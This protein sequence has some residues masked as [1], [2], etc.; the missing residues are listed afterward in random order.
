VILARFKQ[1]L[2][3]IRLPLIGSVTVV[4]VF[5]LFQ[6][7]L[8]VFNSPLKILNIPGLSRDGS[9]PGASGIPWE[10]LILESRLQNELWTTFDSVGEADQETAFRVIIQLKDRLSSEQAVMLTE[11]L[12][13]RF[14]N[15]KDQNRL[16][17]FAHV[18][19]KL[20]KVFEAL[21]FK[22]QQT[23]RTIA[24]V[25]ANW[26]GRDQLEIEP[27]IKA[28]IDNLS[29]KNGRFFLTLCL[30][31]A[32]SERT[33]CLDSIG[34]Y[35]GPKASEALW[36]HAESAAGDKDR[37]EIYRRLLQQQETRPK[38]KLEVL[39]LSPREADVRL[40]ARLIG[41]F[42]L[43]EFASLLKKKT[44]ATPHGDLHKFLSGQLQ[45]LN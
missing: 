5:V 31:G 35:G 30:E 22:Y 10:V 33:V 21:G 40:A 25:I 16:K 3:V 23:L 44:T 39:L 15:P 19:S 32:A 17:E 2:K 13:S 6:A 20:L 41:D 43:R 12:A 37:E 29:E 18:Q 36:A 45:K 7:L 27:E 1:F 24:K 8:L 34:K 42:Q 4:V 28:F 14:K 11:G 9:G 38:A 26:I